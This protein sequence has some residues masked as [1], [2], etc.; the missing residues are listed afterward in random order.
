[1][2]F[3]ASN[4][5]MLRMACGMYGIPTVNMISHNSHCSASRLYH[6]YKFSQR[7]R[8]SWTPNP[9]EHP[10]AFPALLRATSTTPTP[11]AA[12][13]STSRAG[14]LSR[15]DSFGSA[16]VTR[17][18][19]SGS[20]KLQRRDSGVAFGRRESGS[21]F[22]LNANKRDSFHEDFRRLSFGNS[23]YLRAD[24]TGETNLI[25]RDSLGAGRSNSKIPRDYVSK[26]FDSGATTANAA[27][28]RTSSILRKES[29]ADK[30]NDG[31]KLTAANLSKHVTILERS[32][33]KE[34]LERKTSSNEE[35]IAEYL[36]SRRDSGSSLTNYLTSRRIS[37]DSLDARRSS[38]DRG[39]RGSTTSGDF[40]FDEDDENEVSCEMW[41]FIFKR[42]E[43]AFFRSRHSFRR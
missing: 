22:K 38:M 8:N 17:R 7:K 27:P 40:R 24:S 39:R 16:S 15:K 12:A 32:D 4:R 21:S 20:T 14:S 34:P 3:I 10:S 5:S 6:S 13:A 37:I 29:L 28:R 25:R 26:L 9:L 30:E 42:A 36:E 33:K 11:G 2:H 43:S 1:M 35:K 41:R 19:S 31:T 18:D 23:I